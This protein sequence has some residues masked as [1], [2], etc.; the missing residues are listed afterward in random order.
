[1]SPLSRIVA[2]CAMRSATADGG[3]FSCRSRGFSFPRGHRVRPQ[4][5]SL[6]ASKH[7]QLPPELRVVCKHEENF[8][9]R[10]RVLCEKSEHLVLQGRVAGYPREHLPS[11][12]GVHLQSPKD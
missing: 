11:R 8:A 2:A 7:Q 12:F 9:P 5:L 4:S 3:E 10:F 6:L 1:M